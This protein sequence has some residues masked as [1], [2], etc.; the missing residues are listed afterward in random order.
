MA[1]MDTWNPWNGYQG[2]VAEYPQGLL[3][4]M[5]AALQTIPTV[6]ITETNREIYV[7][8]SNSNTMG[9]WLQDACKQE[10]I[11]STERTVGGHD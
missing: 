8:N 9:A 3:E 2:L 10:T 4:D 11:P 6:T 7:N 5:I 1:K